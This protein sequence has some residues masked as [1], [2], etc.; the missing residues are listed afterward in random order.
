[1]KN[2]HINEIKTI[3]SDKGKLSQTEINNLAQKYNCTYQDIKNIIAKSSEEFKSQEMKK[4]DIDK[5]K[6]QSY[7]WSYGTTS[8]RVS[9]L[10]YKIEKQLIRLNELW[11][12]YQSDNWIDI[13]DIYFEML[14]EENL[15]QSSAKDKNKDARQKTS[16]LKDLGLITEDRKVTEVGKEI[17]R[18][19]K[20]NSFDY[21]NIFFIRNDSFIYFKQ[22][23]KI[24]FSEFSN[25]RSYSEF[26]INPFLAIIYAIIELKFITKDEL[27][28]IFPLVKNNNELKFIVSELKTKRDIDL[29]L[30]IKNQISQMEN[31]QF[32]LKYFLEYED[33]LENFEIILMDRKSKENTKAYFELYKNLLLYFENKNSYNDSQKINQIE[34]II[35][36][37]TK[38]PIKNRVKYYKL[39]FDV[40]KKTT[41]NF[42][43]DFFEN[44]TLINS[45]NIEVF[46]EEIFYLIHSIKWHTNLEEYYDL[47]RRFLELSDVFIFEEEKIFL[48]D[49]VLTFMDDKIDKLLNESLSNSKDEYNNKLV[50]NSNLEDISIILKPNETELLQ[51]LKYKFKTLKDVDNLKVAISNIKEKSK[52]ERFNKLIDNYFSNNNL[53]KLFE[54]IKKREDSS[55]KSYIDWECDVPT[56]FEYLIGI[57][58]Y[59][60]SEHKGNLSKFL[61]MSLDANLLPRRFASGGKADIVY[62]Y[63]SHHLIIE[64]TLS[65]KTTQRKMELEPVSRHLGRYLLENRGNH[66]ALFIAPYLDPNV[67]VGF[68]S[69]HKL[70]YYDSSNIQN[71]VE[72]LKIIPLDI[73]D[74]IKILENSVTYEKFFNVSEKAF[75]DIEKDG[76]I[77]YQNVL[78]NKLDSIYES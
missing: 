48:D 32:A 40:T 17:Y 16:S 4:Q 67:L 56:I 8:F 53:I 61:N 42:N 3:L 23:L 27:T 34:K 45:K 15:S 21:D 75:E 18:I 9:E 63:D 5:I 57:T 50:N 11:D 73:D 69:Y 47:N 12:K 49:I 2:Q 77:W 72:N 76:F 68:R 58:W 24:E 36:S 74:I 39:F 52:I 35:E 70:R 62:E 41:N 26:K 6:F 14:V 54:Q 38:V 44:E 71:Y 78:Q 51:K 31:Y 29:F 64:V 43:I 10:K 25:S 59:K 66:Y 55:I 7:S 1:M 20:K 65:D 19:N 60:I 13:Q 30:I 46:Y 22:L 28:Y 37:I 33:S